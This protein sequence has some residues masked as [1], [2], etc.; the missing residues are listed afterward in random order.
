[1]NYPDIDWYKKIWTLKIKEMS[2]VE[3]T[4]K[5][6]DFIEDVLGLKGHEKI[7]DLACGYGRHSIELAKRG[8]DVTGYDI[9][10]SYVED[11]NKTAQSLGLSTKFYQSDIRDISCN[12]TFDV[13]LNLAD[14]A[15]GYLEDDEENL[16][17]FD[18]IAKHLKPNGQSLIDICNKDYALKHFPK[19]NWE[20]GKSSISLSWFD[21]NHQSQRMLYG[22]FNLKLGS[23][24]SIPKSLDAHS[25]TR[26]YDYDEIKTI[27]QKRDITTYLSFGDYDKTIPS[28]SDHLQLIIV[29]QKK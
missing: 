13:I 29:S 22:G 10:E 12:E 24:V 15:I 16:K 1:M 23:E 20:L 28:D 4:S 18:V 26:L 21:F 7:L 27:F 19:K 2:W 9:T 8:Y 11:A 25:C 6:V 17:I 14:G 5:Q 3:E